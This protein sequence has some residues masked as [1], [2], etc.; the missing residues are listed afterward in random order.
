MYQTKFRPFKHQ[1][2]ALEKCQGKEAFAFLMEMRTG[3]TKTTLD[4]FG[5]L[6]LA[7]DAQDLFV[8]APGGVYRTWKPALE[9]HLS[10]DLSERLALHIWKAGASNKQKQERGTFLRNKGRPRCL[11]MN[12]EALS[13]VKAAKEFALEFMSQRSTY[14]AV[15]EST[16]IKNP[17]SQR[18]KFVNQRLADRADVRRILSGLPTPKD[19]L[20]LFSQFEFLDWRIFNQRSYY[21]FRN[22]YAVMRTAYFNNREVKLVQGFQNLGELYRKI[23][24][25]SM[26]VRLEDCTD[27][28]EKAYMTRE[29]A[30]TDEQKRIYEDMRK[31]ATAHINGASHVTA[32]TVVAQIIRLHQ[33]L[34]G[35]TR[36]ET[37]CLIEIPERRTQELIDL[38]SDY[39][40]K[41]IIWCAYDFNV[42]KVSEALEK[43]FGQGCVAKFWGGN[44]SAREEEE[45][46]FLHDHATRFMVS[47]A[48]SGGRGRTWTVANLVVYHSSTPNLEHR[49]QSEERAQA[50]GKSE[51]VAYVDLQVPGTVEEKFVALLRKKMNIA[52]AILNE[53]PRAWLI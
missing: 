10:D 1:H 4:D 14:M 30:L 17:S 7:G 8:V 37:D 40:G 29:V 50:I 13:S 23:E 9:E 52:A 32:T 43:A 31:R 19:P 39:F 12:V 3:K 47:T 42:Q 34:C 21:S 6:E 5:R 46:R 35:H 33:I 11:L 16:V 51:P 45:R 28:P 27:L 36:D 48:A 38:L 25:F 22:R 44:R 26:R 2:Q 24:P 49:I 15:D 20:D 53:G 41:A 18:T